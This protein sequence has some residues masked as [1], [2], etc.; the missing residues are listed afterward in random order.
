MH[1]L[2]LAR[3]IARIVGEHAGARRVGC[4]RLAVGPLACVERASLEFCW[5]VVTEGTA[6]DGAAL[7]FL[8]AQGDTFVVREFECSEDE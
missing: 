1:E 3:S 4:V 8:E 2:S 5:G 6:L 7:A